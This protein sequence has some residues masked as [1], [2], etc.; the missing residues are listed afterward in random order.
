MTLIPAVVEPPPERDAALE[1]HYT[2]QEVAKFWQVNPN[3][4]RRL[5][6]D[7]PGVLRIV[8]KRVQRGRPYVSL[9]IPESTLRAFHVE[10]SRTWGEVQGRS[11][12]V[13]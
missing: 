6:R 13:K 4:V 3:T 7:H 11:G 12:R 8:T 9:R 5:F 1:R 10:N 2:P